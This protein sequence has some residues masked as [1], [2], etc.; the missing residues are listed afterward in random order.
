MKIQELFDLKGRVA[1]VTG[2][3]K[4]IGFK[5]AEGLAEAGANL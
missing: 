2:G 4:G 3:G 5:M 1:V